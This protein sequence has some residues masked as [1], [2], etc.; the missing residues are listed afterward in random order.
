[1]ETKIGLSWKNLWSDRIQVEKWVVSGA[2]LAL[3]RDRNGAWNIQ[4]LFDGAKHSASV[5]RIIVENSTV[6][7]NFLQQQLI[8]KEIS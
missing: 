2:D 1:K 8:L 4:D 6:R 5:N 7:L 3:T